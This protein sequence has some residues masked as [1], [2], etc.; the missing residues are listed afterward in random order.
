MHA[1]D[2][3]LRVWDMRPFA[4]ANRCMKI[5]SGHQHS[6]EKNLLKC[7]WSADGSQVLLCPASNG[8][9]SSNLLMQGPSHFWLWHIDISDRTGVR[10]PSAGT[11]SGSRRHGVMQCSHHLRAYATVTS[12]QQVCMLVRAYLQPAYI[13]CQV[14][15]SLRREAKRCHCW[16]I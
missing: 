16:A 7:A 12:M 4:P 13:A 14:C 6:Y 15:D 10:A 11:C 5:F 2:N 8:A 3:T 9:A 1:Q